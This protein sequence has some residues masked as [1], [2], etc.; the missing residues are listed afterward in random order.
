MMAIKVNTVWATEI[1]IR[2]MVEPRLCSCSIRKDSKLYIFFGGY[3]IVFGYDD[4]SRLTIPW[5]GVM[6]FTLVSMASPVFPASY[7]RFG[8]I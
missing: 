1:R 2:S 3:Q 5:V 4:I 8:L 7:S 6:L